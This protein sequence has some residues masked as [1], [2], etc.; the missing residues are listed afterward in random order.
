M[1]M[2]IHNSK[3]LDTDDEHHCETA[4][5]MSHTARRL[6][7]AVEVGSDRMTDFDDMLSI[8]WI[9]CVHIS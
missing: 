1:K 5:E 6:I 8:Y 4:M 9:S 3:T 2:M 7:S